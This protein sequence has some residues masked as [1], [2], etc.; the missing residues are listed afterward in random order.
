M[1]LAVDVGTTLLKAGLFQPDGSLVARAEA[2]L[3]LVSKADPLWQESD[4]GGWIRGLAAAV[5]ALPLPGAGG[6][7]AV[8]ASGNGPT[9]VPV[10]AAG[11][12]LAPALTWMDR[13]CVEEARIVSEKRGWPVDPTFSL[14]KALWFLRNRPDIYGKTARFFGCPEY[15]AFVLTGEAAAFLPTPQYTRYYWDEQLLAAVDLDQAKF[16]PFLL[17]GKIMGRVSAAGSA[18]TGVPAGVPVVSGG[19]DFLV[20]LL[21]TA[22]VAAGR[23]CVRSGTSE[24]INLCSSAPTADRRLLCVS[25]IAEG[26]WNVSG[27][28]ST[29]GKALEW[30]RNASGRSSRSYEELFAEIEAVPA[31]AGS[32]LFL[33]YLAGERAPI[34]DPAARGAFV[35]LTLGHGPAEMLRAVAESVGFAIR[36]VVE[37]MEESGLA[38]RDLR[39][40]GRPSRSGTWNQIKADITGRRILVLETPDSDLAGDVC[41]AL[42]ALDRFGSVAEAAEAIVHIGRAFEPDPARKALY[43]G[44]F[45]AYRE[46]YAGLK[47]V[48]AK[49][50]ASRSQS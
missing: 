29:S 38:V 16:P 23:A 45:A 43:D 49:L 21:G 6:L 37:V 27:M 42:R 13:R 26:F 18:A 33:P 7:D 46:S 41:L 32:L 34:W 8:V 17:S 1:I 25:H 48:F 2:P 14:P 28:I 35:G 10:D 36:D 31:G 40:T 30:F 5:R 22:T 24:G 39:T 19:P 15:V 44:M 3:A 9:L 11:M 12:P 47:A 50:S 4:A 20:S